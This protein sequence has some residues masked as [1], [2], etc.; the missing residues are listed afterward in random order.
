MKMTEKE[1]FDFLNEKA[2]GYNQPSY[3]ESDPL[4]I[5]HR[6]ELKQDVEIS[7]FLAATI[8]WG[9]RKSIIKDAEKIMDF[10]GN[11]PYD[12]IMN[13]RENHF[14][15]IRDK[16][17][18]RTFNGEDL[19][20][21]S[22]NLKRLYQHQNSLS[23]YFKTKTEEENFYHALERFRSEFLRDK[24]HRSR[25]HVSSTYKNSAAKRLM[26]FLR[27]MVRKDSK[28]VDL[29]IWNDLNPAKLSCPL[30]V[31]SGRVA[32]SL[33]IL[34]RKQNDWKAVEELDIVLRKYNS[35]DPAI[36]DFALFG[37]GISNELRLK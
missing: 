6:Y 15:K 30:D 19:L 16:A 31:H 34:N 11:S 33:G 24:N 9:N 3:I 29:G 28:G 13:T 20:E 18:H 10:M 14:S 32:R 12:F 1:I 37:L 8:A 17:I 22:M 4:Q 7:A 35:S 26:M 25:K 23:Y 27:W 36:Y 2:D 5:P 21:F